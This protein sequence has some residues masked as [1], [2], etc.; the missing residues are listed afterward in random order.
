VLARE[1]GEDE[2]FT[3]VGTVDAVNPTLAEN[4]ARALYGEDANY[5]E[6]AVVPEDQVHRFAEPYAR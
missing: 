1:H 4:Y 6:M 5:D 3:F 2:T